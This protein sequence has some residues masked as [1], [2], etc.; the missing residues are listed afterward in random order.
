MCPG[1]GSTILN[2]CSDLVANGR[3]VQRIRLHT[4][5]PPS[6]SVASFMSVLPAPSRKRGREHEDGQNG[7]GIPTDSRESRVK[8]TP[9]KSI[10][11]VGMHAHTEGRQALNLRGCLPKL[12]VLDLDKTVRS[13]TIVNY[14]IVYTDGV[15]ARLLAICT[16]QSTGCEMLLCRWTLTPVLCQTVGKA[17]SRQT[18]SYVLFPSATAHSVF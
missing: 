13:S 18:V 16:R 9:A 10:R 8:M 7:K 6:F 11:R 4:R 17:Q 15:F 2:A 14:C 3:P 12:I 1:P 5:E